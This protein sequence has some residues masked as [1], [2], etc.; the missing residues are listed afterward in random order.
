M[1]ID[2]STI[3]KNFEH[4]IHKLIPRT[5]LQMGSEGQVEFGPHQCA[6]FIR[7]IVISTNFSAKCIKN[8]QMFF[9][10]FIVPLTARIS[11][12]QQVPKFGRVAFDH[13]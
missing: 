2:I 5:I 11:N 4:L 10:D 8:R 1:I 3:L 6:G 7:N 12:R 13:A 9:G